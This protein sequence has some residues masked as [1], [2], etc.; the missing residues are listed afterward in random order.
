M[1]TRGRVERIVLEYVGKSLQV[2]FLSVTQ[3]TETRLHVHLGRFPVS[4]SHTAPL[5]FFDVSALKSLQIEMLKQ[6][7]ERYAAAYTATE[8][9]E[10][11][12]ALLGSTLERYARAIVKAIPIVGKLIWEE[13]EAV[14]A[15]AATYAL[16]KIAVLRLELDQNFAEL[17]FLALKQVYL[18]EF[19]IGKEVAAKIEKQGAGITLLL[20]FESM[21]Q[22]YQQACQQEKP[23]MPADDPFAIYVDDPP[24]A[25]TGETSTANS[26]ADSGKST[27]T[28]L[29]TLTQLKARGLITD[30]EFVKYQQKL[31][32]QH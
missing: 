7:F 30:A 28:R 3:K 18:A 27:A 6:L 14:L 25:S 4:V 2:G 9:N 22:R 29:E 23:I 15:G 1:D 24:A 13:S 10:M 26:T 31:L 19:N 12:A 8:G 21:K 16:A 5:E 17:N 20:D 32:N 11:I